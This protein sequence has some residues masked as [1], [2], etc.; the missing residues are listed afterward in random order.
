MAHAGDVKAHQFSEGT[1]LLSGDW[2]KHEGPIKKRRLI[3]RRFLSMSK[4]K[5]KAGECGD[6]KD[7]CHKE[8]TGK[9]T[10][11]DPCD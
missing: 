7:Q 2:K 6:Y 3:D 9:K 11:K 8:C 1:A 4:C 10:D 5:K